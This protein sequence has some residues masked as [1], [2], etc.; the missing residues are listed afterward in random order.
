M[1]T[2]L[3]EA[4]EAQ[5]G[6]FDRSQAHARAVSDRQLQ[7]RVRR[8]RMYRELPGVY[9]VAG[10]PVTFTTRLEATARWVGGSATFSH[11]TAARLHGFEAFA[12]A[13]EV[14]VTTEREVR[15]EGRAG[16]RVH[17]A[18]SLSHRD[19][20]EL[21]LFRVT[22]VAR[23]LLDLASVLSDEALGA[24]VDEALSR[25]KVKF[26]QLERQLL[27]SGGR[28]G[29]RRLRRVVEER[30]GRGLSESKL[31]A[32]GLSA[33]KDAQLPLPTQQKTFRLPNGRARVDF[34]YERE[35]V[36]V[37]LDGY[38]THSDV[39]SFEADRRRDNALVARG[40]VVLR[41]TWRGLDDRPDELTE[42]LALILQRRG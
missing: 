41:W 6:V 10:V 39:H 18:D 25:R 36:V 11:S 32:K 38:A 8:G 2:E 15:A 1:E 26:E 35:R 19:W 4:A 40:F 31:E 34:I 24:C 14:H 33:L 3:F 12:N 21:P 29:V 20:V 22:S 9:R 13:S 16:L 30:A 27:V 7:Y 17:H 37:E 23:T 42:E 28:R 5:H